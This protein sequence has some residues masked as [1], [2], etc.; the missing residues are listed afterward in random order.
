MQNGLRGNFVLLGRWCVVTFGT[1][2]ARPSPVNYNRAGGGSLS[3]GTFPSNHRP[4]RYEF[5]CQDGP[6]CWETKLNQ[7]VRYLRQVARVAAGRV[8]AGRGLTVF[9]DDIFLV[10]YGRSGSTWVRFLIGNL[11]YKDDPVTFLN[12]ESR[13]PD[14]YIFPDRVLRG[15]HRP[16]ILKSHES[17]DPRYTQ[18]IYVVRDPRDVAVSLYHYDLKRGGI[19]EGYPLDDFVQLFVAGSPRVISWGTWAEHVT[20]W[21]STRGG[22]DSFL[23]LRYEDLQADLKQELARVA[24]W[25]KIDGGDEGL[26]RAVELSSMDRMK[27]LETEQSREWV[28][29]KS[30]RQDKTFVRSGRTGEW[31]SVLS[32][33]SVTAIET[34]FGPVMQSLGYEM[35]SE[36]AKR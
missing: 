14:I 36:A 30:T 3:R 7:V 25:L 22:R 29:T 32:E 15:Q 1:G 26:T 18:I 33:A 20:S 11:V 34:A 2:V 13:I 35:T 21:L 8:N 5:G 6:R 9:P 4:R 31:R 19:K 28:E 24:A 10:S 27:K 23:L 16:R 12:V 17:F